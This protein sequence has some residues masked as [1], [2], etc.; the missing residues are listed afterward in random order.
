M[1]L[2]ALPPLADNQI[3]Q[4]QT[5]QL[6]SIEKP[7]RK[8]TRNVINFVQVIKHIKQEL[9][10]EKPLDIDSQLADHLLGRALNIQQAIAGRNIFVRMII[11]ANIF[12]HT[13][14]TF[15]RQLHGLEKELSHKNISHHYAAA[16]KYPQLMSDAKTALKSNDD[17]KDI[18]TKYKVPKRL[19]K[20]NG[21]HSL[22]YHL[23]RKMVL[24]WQEIYNLLKKGKGLEEEEVIELC[25]CAMQLGATAYE[26]SVRYATLDAEAQSEN[27]KANRFNYMNSQGT[28]AWVS[29]FLYCRF[30][31]WL[32]SFPVYDKEW[33]YTA[34]SNPLD[35]HFYTP[36]CRQN[37]WRET[38]NNSIQL[39]LE[40][41]EVD[42]SG[43]NIANIYTNPDNF[44]LKK[45]EEDFKAYRNKKESVSLSDNFKREYLETISIY[46]PEKGWCHAYPDML[47]ELF[48]SR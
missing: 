2:N 14:T 22:I 27:P 20:G 36:G 30:Y 41:T 4:L 29:A 47:R 15:N 11:K 1:S 12:I 8:T 7:T 44:H 17:F 38:Y 28:R 40:E 37:V 19:M 6:T 21:E 31:V 3:W 9:A 39:L 13:R 46:A 34:A 43:Q 35:S 48:N 24:N 42:Y 5:K 10:A 23:E 26:L 45:E 32:R 18:C 25:D 33:H 16:L